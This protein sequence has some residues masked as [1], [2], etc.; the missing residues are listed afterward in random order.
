MS[1]KFIVL[2]ARRQLLGHKEYFY[3]LI[4]GCIQKCYLWP[5]CSEKMKSFHVSGRLCDQTSHVYI[6]RWNFA[7][8]VVCECSYTFQLS[9]KFVVGAWGWGCQI[10]HTTLSCPIAYTTAKA[11][12]L[13]TVYC[14]GIFDS[15]PV[16]NM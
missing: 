14:K 13:Q 1:V 16:S 2:T 15:F 12:R 11:V 9:W 7:S 10:R 3:V 4:T 5:L 6:T 8:D